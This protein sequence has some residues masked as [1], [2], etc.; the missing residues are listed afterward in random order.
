MLEAVS[1]ALPFLP[2]PPPAI[3]VVRLEGM[4]ARGGRLSRALSLPAVESALDRAFK[5]K[6]SPAVAL[7]VNSPGGSPVQSRLIH[8]RVRELAQRHEKRVFVFCEDLAASG[9][10]MIALAGDEIWADA[11]SIVGSIG[12]VGAT[13]GANEAIA[14]LGIER[15]VYTAG[16]FK[17][18]LDPFKPENPDDVAWVKAL[19]AELH[20]E[21]IALVRERRGG[22]LKETA[23]LF[24]GE[25]WLARRALELGLIDGVG[26]VREVLRERY[27]DNVRFRLMQPGRPPLLARLVGRGADAM[28][29]ALEERMA[30]GRWGL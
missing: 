6:R 28:L 17:H 12:V 9:G 30:W 21:F 5:L 16:R 7:L 13:F 15:R 29:D 10:Y 4:I 8:D 23:E 18:R 3:P 11:S 22:K 25:V 14:K 26:H 1:R 2:P 20:S 19:Q 24:E 27:G